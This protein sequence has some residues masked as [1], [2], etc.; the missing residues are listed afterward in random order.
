MD[1][2]T[3]GDMLI[4]VPTVYRDRTSCRVPGR[5]AT[6]SR[7]AVR[8]G[9]RPDVATSGE[10]FVKCVEMRIT[11][12]CEHRTLYSYSTVSYRSRKC[13]VYTV[14]SY[15]QYDL[16]YCTEYSIDTDTGTG[17]GYRVQY[18]MVY[19]ILHLRRTS[20]FQMRLRVELWRHRLGP[21][22]AQCCLV[23]HPSR[24]QKRQPRHNRVRPLG[25]VRILGQFA[26]TP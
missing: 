17:T 20:Y 6:G 23:F 10:R 14:Y 12:R 7:E 26:L 3:Y 24:Q 22:S 9:S 1:I 25:D 16:L 19:S 2:Y 21:K 15:I 18:A 8:S 5:K 4:R 11:V 13:T